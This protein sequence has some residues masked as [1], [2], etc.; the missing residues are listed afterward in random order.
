MHAAHCGGRRSLEPLTWSCISHHWDATFVLR[1]DSKFVICICV[2]PARFGR[3]G[4]RPGQFAVQSLGGWHSWS[5]T[6]PILTPHCRIS[7]LANVL[8]DRRLASSWLEAER[9]WL[10]MMRWY[11]S[12]S[13]NRVS[14]LIHEN[15]W[16]NFITRIL[17]DFTG[18][19]C[20]S[21]I[22][23]NIL[24]T[25]NY[26]LLLLLA[27]LILSNYRRLFIFT[28][29]MLMQWGLWKFA[30]MHLPSTL[31]EISFADLSWAI[32]VFRFLLANTELA[33]I[34][35]LEASLNQRVARRS[36]ISGG[37]L[38]SLMLPRL[39]S[40]CVLASVKAI[41]W[42]LR[43]RLHQLHLDYFTICRTRI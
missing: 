28:V 9:A 39:C 8:H 4:C 11:F 26:Y 23:T 14:S 38:G 5:L 29:L 42:W 37:G 7:V 36:F 35:S 22:G 17:L 27:D 32:Y 25:G 16:A 18:S 41:S 2:N 12:V 30:F 43:S 13:L 24:R 33:R 40:V 21:R 1:Q 15:L 6:C 20:Q 31:A 19:G 10:T 3:G 34:V